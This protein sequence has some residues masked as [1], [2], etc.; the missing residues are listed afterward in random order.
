MQEETWRVI[1]ASQESTQKVK[2]TL[3]AQLVMRAITVHMR[4]QTFLMLVTT[5]LVHKSMLALQVLSVLLLDFFVHKNAL[6]ASIK[7]LMPML[8]LKLLVFHAQMAHIVQ[9]LD[10]ILH[11]LV[12]MASDATV[13]KVETSLPF[14]AVMDSFAVQQALWLAVKKPSLCAQQA[15][16]VLVDSNS[17]ALLATSALR[18]LTLQLQLTEVLESTAQPVATVMREPLKSLIQS[19]AL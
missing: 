9:P 6:Q 1:H 15:T 16:S 18:E 10:L 4:S 8:K 7:Q 17:N 5:P 14:F 19:L 3:S 11:L 12:Q 13:S 2:E